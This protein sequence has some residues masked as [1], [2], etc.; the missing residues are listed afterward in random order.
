[1]S[2]LMQDIERVLISKEQ[3]DATVQKLGAQISKDYADKRPLL[4]GVLKGCVVFFSDLIRKID[5]DC[6]LDFMAVSS[7][8]AGKNTTGEVKVLK[9]VSTTIENKHI[10]IVED[11]VDSG[12]TLNYLVNL[13]KFRGASSVEICTLLNKPERRQRD[14]YP[15]YVGFEI[16]N[17]F[18]VGYGLDYDEKFRNLPE[19]CIMKT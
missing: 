18:V 11:I 19:V 14:V 8:G 6:Q 15:K 2:K 9:D 17:E 13:L 10:I 1:M 12:I 3:L 7:Y 5:I 16:P 4:I